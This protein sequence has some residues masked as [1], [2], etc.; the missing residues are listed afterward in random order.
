MGD[1]GLTMI[2]FVV[3]YYA[4]SFS[5]DLIYAL[6][7][8]F[9]VNR[10][11]SERAFYLSYQ[12]LAGAAYLLSFMLPV[13]VLKLRMRG[14]GEPYRSMYAEP[15]VS[16]YL[17]LMIFAVIMLVR[18]VS[19]LNG[20]WVTI[21]FPVSMPQMPQMPVAM[22]GYDI[23]LQFLVTC[24][25]PGFCEEFLFRGAILT[26]CMPFGRTNAIIISSLLF[27]M[28]H[29]NFSQ[30][31]Y[32]FVAGILLGLVYEK[33]G[34]I[35]NCIILHVLNN[36][37]ALID[38]VIYSNLYAYASVLTTMLEAVICLVGMISLWILIRRF[39]SKKSDLAEGFYQKTLPV[40]DDYA[41]CPIETGRA[42]KL[43]FTPTMIIFIVLSV[44]ST[45]F[46]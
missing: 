44:I 39:F 38:E 17:P 12:L 23:V 46:L 25:V 42:V 2:A 10:L 18:A 28:M 27:S 33:T 45:V 20:I 3:I 24:L 15:K 7:R 29:A 37:F 41:T 14:S 16:G 34:S 11:V 26:N 6:L 8:G 4:S 22:E 43:F 21:V 30:M 31:L 19:Y 40:S 9:V 32:T 5:L 36:F 1:I 13:L 35:W